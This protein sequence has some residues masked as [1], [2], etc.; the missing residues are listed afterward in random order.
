MITIKPNNLDT[1]M[2]VVVNGKITKED[3]E[4]F[5]TEFKQELTQNHKEN[6]LIAVHE[7]EG[8]SMQ[9]I[10]EDL[11]FSAKHWKEFQ[12]IAVFTDKKWIEVSSKLSNFVPGVDVKHFEFGERERALAW[13][14]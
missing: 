13:L 12:K 5:E 3:I 8:C 9:A 10:I 2:E 7:I 14:A 4:E 1:V 6:L 11:K